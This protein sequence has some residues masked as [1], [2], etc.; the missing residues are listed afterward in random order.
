MPLPI[1]GREHSP[2]AQGEDL[3]KMK[4]YLSD[5]PSSERKR[6]TLGLHWNGDEI[7]PGN[8]IGAV[9]VGAADDRL[10]LCVGSK[11]ADPKMDYIAMFA[12]CC[13]DSQIGEQMHS[14]FQVW[15]EQKLIEIPNDE[16]FSFMV[17]VAFLRE[18]NT[19]C[20]RHLRRHFHRRRENFTGKVKGKIIISENLRRNIGHAERMFCEYQAISDDILEN[21]ILRA[22]LEKAARYLSANHKLV[23][24][25]S[26]MQRWVHAC[27]AH[28]HGVSVVHITPRDFCAV[29]S[30]GAFAPYYRPIHLAKAVLC[31]FGFNPH[32]EQEEETKTPPYAIDSE[33]LFE[34]Y[35][36]LQLRR[37]YENIVMP[38]DIR[39]PNAGFNV[40]V[41]PD[42]YVPRQSDKTPLIIDAKYKKLKEGKPQR[43]DL[44]QVV[45]YSRHAGLL[46]EINKAHEDK[47]DAEGIALHLAYPWLENMLWP[48]RDYTNAFNPEV[49]IYKIKC[50]AMPSDSQTADNS[51]K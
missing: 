31:H 8:Y 28:L 11:F 48:E 1:Y 50:P 16:L 45:A 7:R 22:A 41:R 9:W 3:D 26:S 49:H 35:A 39:N 4:K 44:Y 47:N 34:R 2:L 38:S 6:R 29:R 5:N 12:D 42:F 13:A 37:E 19:L 18:L 27:R 43:E 15:T 30:R 33:K 36:E 14:C 21:R 40:S 32:A 17:V 25:H 51:K 20:T 24:K 23:K 46:H 10:V